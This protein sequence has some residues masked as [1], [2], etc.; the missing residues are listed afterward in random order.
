M[1]T[2]NIQIR[3]GRKCDQRDF[4]THTVVGRHVAFKIALKRGK[5]ISPPLVQ[6]NILANQMT[7][8]HVETRAVCLLGVHVL[9]NRLFIRHLESCLERTKCWRTSSG[10]KFKK[11]QLLLFLCHFLI[12]R[13]FW[14]EMEDTA[15]AEDF[16][17]KVQEQK[18]LVA[19]S[20]QQNRLAAFSVNLKF[21]RPVNDRQR[22]QTSTLI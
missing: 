10:G 17:S 2:S 16:Y 13:L 15:N 19:I 1:F 21:L 22:V 11:S 4:H 14:H 7:K 5:E 18:V 20:I 8:Y 6:V 9:D 3:M 12:P